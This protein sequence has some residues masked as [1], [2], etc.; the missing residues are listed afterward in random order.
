MAGTIPPVWTLNNDGQAVRER[1]F[2]LQTL[3]QRARVARLPPFRHL[4][5]K[6]ASMKRTTLGSAAR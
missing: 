6:A 1:L 4:L 3:A 2:W 5:K